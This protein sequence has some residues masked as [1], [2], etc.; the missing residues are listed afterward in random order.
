MVGRAILTVGILERCRATEERDLQRKELR[1]RCSQ[2]AKET[3]GNPRGGSG[4]LP[5]SFPTERRKSHM[6]SGR[7]GCRTNLDFLM[8]VVLMTLKVQPEESI[9]APLREIRVVGV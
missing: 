7:G 1:Q 4:W 9:M 2:E 3:L 6:S 8:L 5:R